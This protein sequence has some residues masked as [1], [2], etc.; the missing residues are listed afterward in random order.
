MLPKACN[1][2]KCAGCFKIFKFFKFFKFFETDPNGCLVLVAE[3]NV[4][5]QNAGRVADMERMVTS[6]SDLQDGLEDATTLSN[7]F[8]RFFD[9]FGDASFHSSSISNHQLLMLESN[10]MF[11]V[12]VSLNH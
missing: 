3:G 1:D 5:K 11:P 4:R 10:R 6:D 12:S 9:L 7:R 8:H 2:S